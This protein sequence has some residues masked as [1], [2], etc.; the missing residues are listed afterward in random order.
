MDFRK[1]LE[2][3]ADVTVRVGI[4]LKAGQRLIVRAP[5]ESAPFTRCV[6]EAAYGA[7]ARLV[8]VLWTDDTVD[9]ARF[10]LAPRDSFDELPNSVPDALLKAG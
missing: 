6:V 7:G 10:R 8:E 9:L 2:K 5:V 1:S 3:Y 4:G